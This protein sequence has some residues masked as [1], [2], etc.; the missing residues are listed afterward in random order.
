[1]GKSRINGGIIGRII[2]GINKTGWNK[3]RRTG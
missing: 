3:S 2:G 1:L